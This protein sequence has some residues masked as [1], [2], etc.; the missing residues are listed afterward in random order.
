LEDLYATPDDGNRYEILDD[1]IVMTP[2]PGTR[3]QSVVSELLV[4][5]HAAARERGLKVFTAP[6]AWRIG[7]GY[8]PEPDIVV[9]H[10]ETVTPRAIAGPP[11]L[12]VEVLSPT[13]RGRDLFEKRRIYAEGGAGWYWIVDPDEP[14]L[15]V[16]RLAGDQYELAARIVNAEVYETGEPMSLRVVPAELVR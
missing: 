7:P 3:H 14:S 5:L 6:V 13:G 2:P 15:T 8:V 10:P 9:A 16:L 12:V 1:A 4:I 11:V